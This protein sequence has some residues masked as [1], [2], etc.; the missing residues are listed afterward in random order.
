MPRKTIETSHDAAETESV[1]LP[2]IRAFKVTFNDG[3]EETALAHYW[4]IST[5]HL[6]FLEQRM[7]ASLKQ[8]VL[9]HSRVIAQGRWAEVV[10]IAHEQ[11]C[12]PGT[13]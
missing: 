2:S 10:E 13:H 3:R 1:I 9:F 5:G 6:I 4:D 7:D 8:L 11:G 12:M